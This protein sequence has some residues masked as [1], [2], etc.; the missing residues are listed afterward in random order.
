[1]VPMKPPPPDRAT[2]EALRDGV[3]AELKTIR[4]APPADRDANREKELLH[5]QEAIKRSLDGPVK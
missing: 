4:G 2:L 5:Q 3:E 1:M